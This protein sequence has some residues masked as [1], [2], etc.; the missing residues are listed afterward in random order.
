MT[1]QATLLACGQGRH[2]V[3]TAGDAVIA[4]PTPARPVVG[5][6]EFR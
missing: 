4:D 3:P 1:A 2:K 5:R 6:H